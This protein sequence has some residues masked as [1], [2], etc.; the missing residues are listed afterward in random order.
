M[1]PLMRCRRA[2]DRPRFWTSHACGL[3]ESTR[4]RSV[5][6]HECTETRRRVLAR[7]N[8]RPKYMITGVHRGQ[9]G[10]PSVLSVLQPA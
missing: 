3:R 7:S 5:V 2:T 1:I 9:Y 6:N 10:T 8:N 4:Q